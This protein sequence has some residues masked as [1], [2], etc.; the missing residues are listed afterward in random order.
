VTYRGRVTEVATDAPSALRGA[1]F[2]ASAFTEARAADGS[3]RGAYATLFEHLDAPALDDASGWMQSDLDRRGVVFG[4]E[5]AHPFV[6]D[7]VPRIIAAEEWEPLERGLIQRIRALG[8]FLADV[9]GA[10]R[11]VADGVIPARVIDEAE[12]FEPAMAAASAPAVRAHVAGP[13]LVRCPDGRFRV[14]EDN[15]RAPSGFAYLLAA[16]EAISPLILASGLRPRGLD[17]GLCAL[18][19]AL[20]SAAPAGVEEPRIVLLN[21]GPGAGTLFEHRELASRLG[22]EIATVEQLAREGDRLVGPGDGGRGRREI[23]VIYRRV[24]DES[25]T[26]SSGEPTALG[27]LI[28]PPLM[29]GTLGCVNSPGSGIADDK[30]V[31]AYVERMIRFYLGEE[32]ILP[33]VP[34]FDLGDPEQ[35]ARALPRLGELVV[36]PR[37]EFGGSGVL[38]GPLATAA[39]LRSAAALIEANPGR[40]VAQEAV[41]LSVHPTV[42]DGEL[43]SRHVDLRPFVF[44]SGEQIRVVPSGLTRFARAEGEMIVNSG[45]GG[46]AKDTWILS[47]DGEGKNP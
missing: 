25:L 28:G 39:E 42:V 26:G 10:R 35:L 37:S 11:I 19:D 2:A 33:S 1:E 14:L 4:G 41:A 17:E 13:D 34:S 21:D 16:R 31:H 3:P 22:L 7:A 12:W 44:S 9:Y 36:K 24:D 15:M 45:Q 20:R 30:A 29:A 46:G 43:R 38:V 8:E 23:D 6:V 32:P 40:W 5:D 18:R 27:E 47:P